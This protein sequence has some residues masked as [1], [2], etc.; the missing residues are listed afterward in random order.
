MLAGVE[1]GKLSLTNASSVHP[2]HALTAQM[3]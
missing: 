3:L 2:G 1:G